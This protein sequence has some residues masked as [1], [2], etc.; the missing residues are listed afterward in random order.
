M[1]VTDIDVVASLAV[2]WREW[3]R[4]ASF[5]FRPDCCINGT[6][7]VTKALAELDV[8]SRPVS[9]EF[10]L[11]NQAGYQL[12]RQGVEIAEWPAHAW[13]LGVNRHVVRPVKHGQWNGHL[14][15]EGDGWTLDISAGQF[16]RS[17]RIVIDGPQVF[18]GELPWDGTVTWLSD[19]RQQVWAISRTGDASWRTASGWHRMHDAEVREIVRRTQRRLSRKEQSSGT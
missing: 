7:V 13:S 4:T 2:A 3:E 10:T 11:F 16:D 9:V 17:P 1:A 19:P 6:R 15:A 5:P 18:H 14:M 8:S 12:W